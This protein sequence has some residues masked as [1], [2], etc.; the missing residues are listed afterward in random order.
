MSP[1]GQYLVSAS[2]DCT[3]RL[4][5]TDTCL[6]RYQWRFSHPV[7]QVSWNPL[8]GHHLVAAATGNSVVLISTGTGDRDSSELSDSILDAARD[9]ANKR[10]ADG[11]EGEEE[12]EEEAEDG[13]DDDEDGEGKISKRKKTPAVWK[14]SK[15]EGAAG[16]ASSLRHGF[17]VG[18]VVEL[19]FKHPVVSATWHHKGDYFVSL[20]PSAGAASVCIHQVSKAKTQQPFSKAPGEVQAVA[21][22]PSRPVLVV[23]TK[24]HIKLYHLVEQKL[25]KKLLSGCKWLSCL[26]VHPSGD[27]ILAGSYDRRVVWFDL[28]LSSTPY[29]TLK[30][31]EK[32]LRAVLYHRRFPL[33]ASASD[34]GNV[35]IFHATVY[36]YVTLSECLL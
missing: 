4:W 30:F 8:P 34:D 23:A 9:A 10:Q 32:A 25:I 24:Q 16:S 36:K 35:H 7:V 21:F 22:H 1:D 19:S 15:T 31:H 11:D 27:H 2:D 33:L 17:V 14:L 3:V 12:G 13:D 5:E 26:D 18:P 6:C 28:D 20:S 29:K